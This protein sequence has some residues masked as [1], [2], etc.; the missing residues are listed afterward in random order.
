[1]TY[2]LYLS[3]RHRTVPL[4][5]AL[6]LS[7]LS[8][9]AGRFAREISLGVSMKLRALSFALA[10]ASL[11]APV[12]AQTWQSFTAANGSAG[13]TNPAG[14][15]NNN[16]DDNTTAA[17]VCNL[18]SILTTSIATCG[19]QQPAGTLPLGTAVTGL[20]AANARF[21]SNGTGGPLSFGLG[22]GSWNLTMFGRVAG[23]NMPADVSFYVFNADDNSFTD[24]S[25]VSNQIFTTNSALYFGVGSFN[26]GGANQQTFFSTMQ[27]TPFPPVNSALPAT[28]Q[29]VAFADASAPT[30][31]GGLLQYQE[32]YSYWLGAEDNACDRPAAGST[33]PCASSGITNDRGQFSDRDYNDY[34]LRVTAVPEPSTYALMATGLLAMGA[35]ARRRRV[36]A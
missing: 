10:T 4:E 25:T 27:R 16:S 1:M 33:S 28:Q 12:H 36:K 32:G 31:L 7:L 24:I 17:D 29:W 8:L 26:P 2:D 34:I 19:S 30:A 21:L 6:R 23:A 15:W 11:V 18:G 14:Y 22:A 13:Y 9:D 3:P 5:S 20:T 35:A